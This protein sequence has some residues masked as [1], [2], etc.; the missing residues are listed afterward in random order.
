MV[1]LMMPLATC[2]M[3][4]MASHDQKSPVALHFNLLDL[5]NAEVPLM[6]LSASHGASTSGVA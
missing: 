1:L 5:R 6:T 2:D 3:V 4:P